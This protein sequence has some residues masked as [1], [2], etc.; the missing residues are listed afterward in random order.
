MTSDV[1]TDVIKQGIFVL[2]TVITP[3]MLLSLLVGLTISVFQAVTQINEQTLTFVPKIL[4]VFLTLAITGG[5][6]M[7]KV[8]EYAQILW[9]QYIAMI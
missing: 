4:V 3:V 1:F 5:W 7:Q 8:V 2:L 6:I 9:T